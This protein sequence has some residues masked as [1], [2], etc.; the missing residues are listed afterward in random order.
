MSEIPAAFDK[1]ECMRIV[2]MLVNMAFTANRLNVGSYDSWQNQLTNKVV[3]TTNTFHGEPTRVS[4]GIPATTLQVTTIAADPYLALIKGILEVDD[5]DKG[6]IGRTYERSVYSYSLIT[7]LLAIPSVTTTNKYAPILRT[8]DWDTSL[9]DS[10]EVKPLFKYYNIVEGS[11]NAFSMLINAMC[12]KIMSWYTLQGVVSFIG[13]SGSAGF[14][15]LAEWL[16]EMGA[17]LDPDIKEGVKQ[18]REA[19]GLVDHV[20]NRIYSQIF[21]N[22]DAE[23][24]A[25]AM[26]KGVKQSDGEA[27]FQMLDAYDRFQ[28]VQ[29][30]CRR[31]PTLLI[32]NTLVSTKSTTYNLKGP[33]SN[34]AHT[35]SSLNDV[36]GTYQVTN[37]VQT[38]VSESVLKYATPLKRN[39]MWPTGEGN[40]TV[41]SGG[42]APIQYNRIQIPTSN[43]DDVKRLYDNA[44][45]TV[46]Q[47]SKS[48]TFVADTLFD[49]VADF[50]SSIRH[51]GLKS[52]SMSYD[53]EKSRGTYDVSYT[54]AT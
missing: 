20:V 40:L 16:E 36:G 8:F 29:D 32:K 21:A 13:Y 18:L 53:C 51:L 45:K 15:L 28:A 30:L 26:Q 12:T 54:Y 25:L 50:Y 9:V 22:V 43:W 46:Y 6:P 17:T 52:A 39:V 24:I 44:P 23:T 4:Q 47:R 34:I 7:P 1:N 38:A 14:V 49:A 42:G 31:N 35:A 27:Y 33:V 10:T 5:S 19:T 41:V 11:R 37:S 48:Y 2:N 3:E